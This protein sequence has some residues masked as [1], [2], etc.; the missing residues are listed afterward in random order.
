MSN[1]FRETSPSRTCTKTYANLVYSCSYVN[2]LKSNDEGE[3]IDPCDTDFNLH[4]ERDNIG[5][6]LPLASSKQ[7]NYM[8]K[9]LKLFMKRYQIIWMLDSLYR[10]MKELKV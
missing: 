8:Y 4:F 6:I 3:Y 10:K 7:G 9:E 1:K 5:N 2:I